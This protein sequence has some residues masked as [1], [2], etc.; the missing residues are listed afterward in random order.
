MTMGLD[1]G[2]GYRGPAGWA[3]EGPGPY[4]KEVGSTVNFQCWGSVM[5]LMFLPLLCRAALREPVLG[6]GHGLAGPG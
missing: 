5:R 6:Q 3:G 4:P 1:G 2:R